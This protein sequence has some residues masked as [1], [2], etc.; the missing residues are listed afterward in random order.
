MTPA[1]RNGLTVIV[2]A[3]AS[4]ALVVAGAFFVGVFDDD[5]WVVTPLGLSL[6][7]GVRHPTTAP[8]SDDVK[9]KLHQL[10]THRFLLQQGQT[11]GVTKT[12]LFTPLDFVTRDNMTAASCWDLPS[13][14]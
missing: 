11:P 14:G 7:L 5:D 3:A 8:P 1:A 9:R 2:G 12:T 13:D 4:A 10:G 6:R